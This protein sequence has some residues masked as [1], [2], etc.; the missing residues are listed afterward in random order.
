MMPQPKFGL[1]AKKEAAKKAAENQLA[2]TQASKAL[3]LQPKDMANR[4]GIIFDDSGSMMGQAIKDAQQG[5]EEFL[6]NCE[7]DN[8][9]VAV[10]GM[11]DEDSFN[12][13]FASGGSKTSLSLTTNLPAVAIWCKGLTASWGTPTLKRL[14]AMF[15]AENVTRVIIFSD[16]RPD[17]MPDVND[18]KWI[19]GQGIAIDTV[20]I[21]VSGRADKEASYFMKQ[22]AERTGGIYLCFER[23]KSNF[24][25][26][27]KYL[28]PTLRHLLADRSFVDKLEGK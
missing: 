20:Y 8:T 6:R 25:Q 17:R 3:E 10:Y 12:S 9:A 19:T 22:L 21:P 18:W 1:A 14:K 2:T 15:Q 7:K 27:F 11:G 4:I 16:G 5:V 23:G 28:A 26:A 13:P 24:A